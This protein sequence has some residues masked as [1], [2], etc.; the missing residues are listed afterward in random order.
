VVRY[1]TVQAFKASASLSTALTDAD[2]TIAL[3]AASNAV[4]HVA[5][6]VTFGKDATPTTRTFTARTS[7]RVTVDDIATI[8]TVKVDGTTVTDYL[9]GPL[10]A[11]VNGRPYTALTSDNCVFTSAKTG[12]IEVT[13]LFGWPAVPAAVPQMVTIIASRLLKRSREA[14]FGV[15]NAGGIEG[16]AIQLARTDPELQLL[17]KPFTR[18]LV[19]WR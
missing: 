17:I 3:D 10:N 11:P 4:D 1:V 8:N 6:R 9:P 7:Q 18:Q 5:H 2:I 12:G 19:G 13:G 16:A 14:P 15:V